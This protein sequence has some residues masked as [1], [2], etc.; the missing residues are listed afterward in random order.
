MHELFLGGGP[1]AGKGAT[2]RG[3]LFDRA[4]SK[5]GWDL[6]PGQGRDPSHARFIELNGVG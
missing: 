6:I 4:L 1:H 5:S 2:G 3:E